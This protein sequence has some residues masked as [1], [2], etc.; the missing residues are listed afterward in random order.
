MLHAF[1]DACCCG[2]RETVVCIGYCLI[3][4][5]KLTVMEEETS[6]VRNETVGSV[7][8]HCPPVSEDTIARGI[9][10]GNATPSATFELVS[11]SVEVRIRSEEA[12]VVEADDLDYENAVD[13]NKVHE[14][15]GTF[16]SSIDIVRADYVAAETSVLQSTPIDESDFVL[17]ETNN[18]SPTNEIA[19]T[20]NMEEFDTTN[21]VSIPI[22]VVNPDILI[23]S[24]KF[25]GFG[26]APDALAFS[27]D[28]LNEVDNDEVKPTADLS[29]AQGDVGDV[30]FSDSAEPAKLA[31]FV[32]KQIDSDIS[33]GELAQEPVSALSISQTQPKNDALVSS[34]AVSVLQNDDFGDS[35]NDEPRAMTGSVVLLVNN[36]DDDIGAAEPLTAISNLKSHVDDDDFGD[37]DGAATAEFDPE[38]VESV[39][40]DDDF[41]DFD[42]A[43]IAASNYR[44]DN[45]FD[46]VRDPLLE[47]L[48]F[49]FPKLFPPTNNG[50]TSI[51]HGSGLDLPLPLFTESDS[52]SIQSCLVCAITYCFIKRFLVYLTPFFFFVFEGFI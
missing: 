13:R 49:A 19:F 44:T 47:R 4:F 51:V 35:G 26:S 36:D 28:L 52:V 40:D 2:R 25:D 46:A 37:F 15:F 24:E 45:P 43:P 23:N 32:E 34:P 9:A 11:S 29:V 21:S 33:V 31:A 22:T 50:E 39:K 5:L 12:S 41:G 14:D 20:E 16:T 17:G 7:D 42:E 3:T 8:V 27:L 38:N 1:D 6:V 18:L 30:A 10:A 48:Y